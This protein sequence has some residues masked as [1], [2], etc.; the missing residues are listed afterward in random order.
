M[1]YIQ[2]IFLFH[3]EIKYNRR[4]TLHEK[5]TKM[6][7]DEMM[8]YIDAHNIN[9]RFNLLKK[10]GKRYVKYLVSEYGYPV[11]VAIEQTFLTGYNRWPY[12]Y[13]TKR[14]ERESIPSEYFGF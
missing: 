5:G 14:V 1:R 2:P 13:K 11:S 12:N 6:T 10:D 7:Y 3:F 8:T 4:K 9:G